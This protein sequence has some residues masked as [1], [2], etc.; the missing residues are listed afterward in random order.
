M[1]EHEIA[2]LLDHEVRR[3]GCTPVVT[4]VAAD[5]RIERYRHPIPTDQRVEGYVMLVSCAEFGG[6]ISNLT[7]FVSFRQLSAELRHKQQAVVNVD[8]AVN[9]QTRPGRTLGQVFADLQ[10]AYADNGANENAQ[11]SATSRSLVPNRSGAAK[12]KPNVLLSHRFDGS[13]EQKNL[14]AAKWHFEDIW[15]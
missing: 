2:G 10:K 12:S 9:A 11:N 13:R 5:G 3:T 8:L 7:R 14:F 4:L 1:S 6:L 15:A